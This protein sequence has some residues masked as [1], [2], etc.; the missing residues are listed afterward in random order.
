MFFVA[1]YEDI[2]TVPT[3]GMIIVEDNPSRWRRGI[4]LCRPRVQGPLD[5]LCLLAAPL[6]VSM[7]Q[8]VISLVLERQ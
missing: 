6:D 1:C 3:P 8:S 5:A 7:L 2:W 4:V